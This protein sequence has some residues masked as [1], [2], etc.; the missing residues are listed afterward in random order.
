MNNDF[1]SMRRVSRKQHL[2]HYQAVRK[3]LPGRAA[4]QYLCARDDFVDTD[5]DTAHQ[6][7]EHILYS[8]WPCLQVSLNLSLGSHLLQ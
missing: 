3:E 8:T 1:Q 7:F 2:V 5:R 4:H 6:W